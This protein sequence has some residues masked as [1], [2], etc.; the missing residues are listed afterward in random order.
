M[1]EPIKMYALKWIPEDSDY[2]G[3]SFFRDFDAPGEPLVIFRSKEAAEAAAVLDAESDFTKAYARYEEALAKWE[4]EDAA[5]DTVRTIMRA[6][7]IDK[8]NLL[9]L[10]TIY[11]PKPPAPVRIAYEVVEVDVR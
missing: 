5:L 1:N 9:V 8:E 3:E 6:K 7:G 11:K 2:W 10:R 4:N